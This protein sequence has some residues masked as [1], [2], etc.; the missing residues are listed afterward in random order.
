MSLGDFL[1][2]SA[3]DAGIDVAHGT[4]IPALKA[5]FK[6][7]EHQERAVKKL[8][9]N[10]GKIIL[11]HEMGT[12]KTVTSI[13]GFEKL[14]HRGK[15][16]KALVVVPSGLRSNYAEGGV[17]KFT[18]S[19]YQVVGSSTERSSKEN[20]VR[21]NG[22][23][24]EK[25]YTIISYAMFRRDPT[26]YMKATGADTLIFDEF[27]KTRNES[28][29]T[30]KA[31]AQAR[32]FAKNFIGMTGSLINNHPAEIATLM[33]LSEMN[34]EMT[35]A[36]F[37]RK[38]TQTIGFAKGFG[39]G[40]KKVIGLKNVPKLIEKTNPRLS[41]VSSDQL[42][43]QT[44]PRK[45]TKNVFVPMSK[46]QYEYYQLALDRLG[47]IKE[48]IVRRDPHVSVKGADQLFAQL[49]KARQISNAVHTARD[50]MTLAQSAG[51][52]PKVKKVLDDAEKHLHGAEDGKVVIYSNLIRGGVD[53]LS[54]GLR[55][56]GI[57]HALFIGKGTEIHGKKVT[58]QT[59]QQGVKAFKGGKKRVIVVSGAGAEGLDLKNATAFYALDGHFNP[60]R[61]LQAEGRARRLGGQ[62]HRP[63]E[64][65]VVDVRRYQS[66]VPESARP[67]FFGKLIGRQAPRTTDEWMY[68]VAGSKHKA[69]KDFYTAIKQAPKH[70]YKYRDEN[71][72]LRYV[73]PKKPKQGFFSKLLSF[74]GTPS[75]GAPTPP[76]PPS[77]P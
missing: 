6:P 62:K 47:P 26:G 39:G 3:E 13:Y 36:Q 55:E 63:K 34:R 29:S 49:S 19:S 58:S 40:K 27:H 72:K 68:G 38:F 77:F 31:A 7:Y 37:K 69:T 45:D 73:Y 33:S 71:G 51:K 14:R 35:P 43:G 70:I 41:Y 74:G 1:V 59:R 52:S 44:M 11:A 8:F 9:N 12:G 64:Q 28:S 48:R 10:R 17:E 18:E 32:P 53:V 50:D 2:K 67:G 4:G 61:I 15:A 65:R 21:P 24:P 16:T 54:A 76:G 66:V 57:P 20:Y 60:E 23:D 46:E 42:K 75:Q 5:W 30:F 22:I 25:T 56:R